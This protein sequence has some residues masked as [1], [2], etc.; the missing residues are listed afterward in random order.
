VIIAMASEPGIGMVG[1]LMGKG[2]LSAV[3]LVLLSR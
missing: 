1:R 2:Y 3:R